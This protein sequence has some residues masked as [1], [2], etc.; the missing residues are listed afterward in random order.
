MNGR[1]LYAVGMMFLIPL[2]VNCG[3]SDQYDTTKAVESV[4][5]FLST[6]DYGVR[7]KT[8]SPK[9]IKEK[10]AQYP[11]WT[12]NGRDKSDDIRVLKIEPPYVHVEVSYPIRIKLDASEGDKF[13]I[14][15]IFMVKKE[16]SGYFIV[17]SK[18]N[19]DNGMVSVDPWVEMESYR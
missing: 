3:F 13:Y 6:D 14:S 5:T 10:L 7:K 16:G 15:Y 9:Y 2:L 4:V 8:I 17:P 19:V 11:D 18:K 12:P 1:A